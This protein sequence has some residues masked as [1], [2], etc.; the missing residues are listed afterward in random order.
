MGK[1]GTQAKAAKPPAKTGKRRP[2]PFLPILGGVTLVALVVRLIVGFQLRAKLGDAV[3]LGIPGTDAQT[4]LMYAR[5]IVDGTFDYSQGF[6]YQPF[7]YAVFLP[8]VFLVFGTGAFG[9][10]L[11]QACLGALT[12]WLTG[13]AFARL[14]GRRAGI[15]AAVLLALSRMHVLYTPFGLIAVLKGF[16][17]ALLFYLCVLAWRQPKRWWLAWGAVGLVAGMANATRGN[18]VLLLPLLALLAVLRYR[19]QG[20]IVAAAV[21]ILLATFYLPQLPFMIANYQAH[22]RWVTS[23]AA[24][25][26]LAIGNTPE[27]PPGGRNPDESIGPMEYANTYSYPYWMELEQ[28]PPPE[29]VTVGRSMWRWIRHQ[30]LAWMELKFRMVLLFWNQTEIPNNIALYLPD[31]SR[32]DVP[33]LYSPLL[34]GFLPIGGLALAGMA[35]ALWRRHH[36]RFVLVAIAMIAV[37]CGSIVLFYILARFRVPLLPWLCGFAGYALIRAWDDYRRYRRERPRRLLATLGLVLAGLLLAGGAY[38]VYRY[39]LEKRVVAVVR[40]DGTR[41]NLGNRLVIFDHGP[42]TF[43]GWR[44]S[45]GLGL[46]GFQIT[47]RFVIPDD[48]P[49]DAPTTL[50]LLI[51]TASLG[52]SVQVQVNDLTPVAIYF[53]RRRLWA[54]VPGPPAGQ[55]S[56]LTLRFADYQVS[57]IDLFVDTQR[58][59]DRTLL[60]G[61]PI[62]RPDGELVADLLITL[63]G[64]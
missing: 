48:V 60:D 18:I 20:R 22:G 53:D 28:R 50:R 31:G 54:E 3:E 13:I 32:F 34:L 25:A 33:L 52:G 17:L 36:R 35:L 40:P 42:R 12:V 26:V 57:G 43:G 27:A 7:Y 9:V 21:A 47:K 46:P 45:P 16:L 44:W 55:A 64:D 8:A 37:Y 58:D 19:H 29:R 10:V 24:G 49:D 15:A 62:T 59:Y 5:Q 56:E 51:G 39:G 41:L 6:Y 61:Q 4:Y 11:V 30:P 23:T 63:D 1:R 38:D 2:H 14:F